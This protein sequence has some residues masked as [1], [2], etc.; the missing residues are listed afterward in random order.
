[1]IRNRGDYWQ[2]KVYAGRD[3]LTGRERYEYDR[4]RTKRE[5][6]RIEAALK[7][8]VAEGRHRGTAARTVT[9]LVERWYEWRQGVKEISPTTLEG[10]R[11][12]IDQRIIPALGRIPVRRLDVE[13][14]DRFYAELRRRGKEGG[15]PLSASTVRAVHTVLS[16]SLRQAVAWGWIAHNPARLATPPSVQRSDVAPPP[17]EQVAGLLATA[18]QRNAKL[19]LFLRLAVVLGARRGEL[20]ALRWQ[21]VHLDRREVLLERGVVY[22]TGQP[23]IDKATKTRSKRRLAMDAGTVELLRAHRKHAEQV[24]RELGFTLPASAYVFTREPDGSRP[25]HPSLVTHQFA[26]LARSLGVRCRLHD[27]RHLMVTYLISQGV[28]WRTAA[29]RA[30]HAGPHMTLGTYAHFQPAQDRAAAELLAALCDGSPPEA[31]R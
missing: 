23:L 31:T 27:L 10:Y 2:V 20:C 12:Q 16:G 3:P 19:G 13:T 28:D 29:G 21:H 22:V 26:D 6:E 30:G 25:V 11:R 5:A 24:A 9:D 17:V 14:L 8:N 1:M 7:T 4:A 15:R 18:L